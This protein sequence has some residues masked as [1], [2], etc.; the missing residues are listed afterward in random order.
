MGEKH[1]P[2]RLR[3]YGEVAP[4]DSFP[5]LHLNLAGQ[6]MR[7]RTAVFHASR[8][9]PWSVCSQLAQ[10]KSKERRART[11]SAIFF[12]LSSRTPHHC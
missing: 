1:G 10:V 9:H 6:Q 2:D 5:N 8:S 12:N 11:I 4:Q 3:R 7:A